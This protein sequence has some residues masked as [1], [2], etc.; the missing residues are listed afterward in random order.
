MK[1]PIMYYVMTGLVVVNSVLLS[2]PNLLGKMGI[3]IYKHYYLRN[4]P[5]TLLTVTL[6]IGTAILSGELIHYLVR[7]KIIGRMVGI[8]LL[9]LLI[10]AGIG[11]LI[12]T[13]ITFSRWT[14][15]HTGLRF[16]LGALLLPTL[17]VAVFINSLVTLSKET[18]LFPLSPMN[19]ENIPPEQPLT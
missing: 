8:V 13:G 18:P 7:S 4:F 16:Q 11:L 14:Y 5:R 15:S 10:A 17:F 2:N 9:T 6:I 12:K 19:D 1:K 3:V